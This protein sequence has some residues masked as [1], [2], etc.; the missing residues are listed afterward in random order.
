MSLRID[1]EETLLISA[2]G[3]AQRCQELEELRTEARSA[4][5]NAYVKRVKMA[6]S[7]TTQRFTTFSRSRHSSSGA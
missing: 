3:Y 7:M 5:Q 6:I 2:E 1:T 4:S